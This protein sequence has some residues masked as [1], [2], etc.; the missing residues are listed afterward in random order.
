[1]RK[2]I[3]TIVCF[4]CLIS[5]IQ[6]QTMPI[7]EN[8]QMAGENPEELKVIYVNKD[9]STHFVAMEDIKYV[10]I[11]IND[12]V[13]DI[14]T[15]NT[16]RVKP[17]KEGASGVITIVTERFLVQYLLVY[18]SDLAKTYT[19]FT[20]PYA[21]LKSYMNPETNMTKSQMYDYAY[22]M[23]ISDNKFYDVS[24]KSNLMKIRLNNIYTFDKYF[25][26]DISMINRSNIRYD[27]DQIRFKI[28]DKKQTKATN[29]QSIEI[30]PL[31]QVNNNKVFKKNYR[32]IFVFEK[33]TFPDEKVLTVEISE[34]Q[35]SGRTITLRIDYA[36]VL[37]ADSF[38]D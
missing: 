24:S 16:L 32:N 20:I 15:S 25:F 26:I 6:A 19:R 28:E 9:V 12:I 38:I 3:A 23:F 11:S 37:N 1:M 8:V 27:I 4:V 21:D 18:T 7:G 31:M 10:D 33:F 36:D 29:F 35:I 13:G 14:P 22:R 5:S 17:I 2:F 34:K 30:L